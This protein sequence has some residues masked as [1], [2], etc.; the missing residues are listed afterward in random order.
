MFQNVKKKE[1]KCCDQME[2]RTITTSLTYGTFK[3]PK[4]RGSIKVYRVRCIAKKEGHWRKQQVAAT[5]I[6]RCRREK[7]VN[8][9]SFS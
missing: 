9:F 3:K 2:D 8:D 5:A 1:R 6:A 4:Q 7:H